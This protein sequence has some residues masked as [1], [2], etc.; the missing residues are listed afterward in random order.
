M[1]NNLS[2]TDQLALFRV[3]VS[4]RPLLSAT[5]G[6][7]ALVGIFFGRSEPTLWRFSALLSEPDREVETLIVANPNI[8]QRQV[9]VEISPKG[10]TLD[11]GIDQ[12]SAFELETK[13]GRLARLNVSE[14]GLSVITILRKKEQLPSST[15]AVPPTLQPSSSEAVM[16]QLAMSY[17]IGLML[18]AYSFIKWLTFG[19]AAL[20]VFN[21]VGTANPREWKESAQ[22]HV[23]DLVR[24]TTRSTSK[25]ASDA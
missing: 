9:L 16:R 25:P 13:G 19:W 17:F 18:Y 8:D 24:W 11:L 7:L 6:I 12:A 23:G 22:R 3:V 15:R 20:T 4:A 5:V 14:R 2:F 21:T 10:Q 1:G